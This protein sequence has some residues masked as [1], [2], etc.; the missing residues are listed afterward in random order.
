MEIQ[1]ES[2]ARNSD[3]SEIVMHVLLEM[4]SD[5]QEVVKLMN[6]APIRVLGDRTI[7]KALADGDLEKVLR[8]L[9]TISGGQNG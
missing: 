6:E 8:Y 4:N 2:V 3:A 1:E 9:Q 7:A 5:A